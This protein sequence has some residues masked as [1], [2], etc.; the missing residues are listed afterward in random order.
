MA[1]FDN[2]S[3]VCSLYIE[4]SNVPRQ[5]QQCHSSATAMFLVSHSNVSRQPKQ[6]PSSATAMSR[7]SH[8][9]VYRQSQRCLSSATAQNASCRPRG[10]P[11]IPVL[12]SR[13]P[14]RPC[15]AN[16]RLHTY[17]LRSAPIRFDVSALASMNHVK[18]E[19]CNKL[20]AQ[21]RWH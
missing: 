9:N 13:S 1:S 2:K 7:V 12:P 6:C 19:Y 5:P 14:P 15:S 3:R 20:L 10:S 18:A 4:L 11:G 8:S 21:F 17:V 16:R